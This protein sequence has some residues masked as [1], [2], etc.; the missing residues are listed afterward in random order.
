MKIAYLSPELELIDLVSMQRIANA[1]DSHEARE[2]E[3]PGLD[4]K[5]SLGNAGDEMD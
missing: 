4:G 3:M 1:R 5:E 2:G